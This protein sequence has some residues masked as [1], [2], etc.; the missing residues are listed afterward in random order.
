MA[1]ILSGGVRQLPAP[2]PLIA[3]SLSLFPP[4]RGRRALSSFSTMAAG[5]WQLCGDRFY[6]RT[7]LYHLDW[8]VDLEDM[9]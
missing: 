7:T 9:R 6:D 4:P 3:F 2:P 1:S 8:D 5:E